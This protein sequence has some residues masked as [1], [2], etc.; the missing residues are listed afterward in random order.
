M[1]MFVYFRSYRSTNDTGNYQDYNCDSYEIAQGLLV[2]TYNGQ[3][4]F[5]PLH[6]V[7]SFEFKE[8]V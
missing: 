6:N 1:R 5:I 7:E 8:G 2:L 4:R 3:E